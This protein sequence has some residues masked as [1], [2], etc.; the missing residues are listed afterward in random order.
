MAYDLAIVG[1]GSAAF[2]AA[3][4]ARQKDLTVVMIERGEVGGTCVNVGCIPSKALLATAEARQ[5]AAAPRF[6][7]IE[8]TAAAVRMAALIKAKDAIVHDLR[9]DKYLDLARE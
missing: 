5:V 8:T 4:R 7:G 1:A 3:I 9:Q 6:P 2:S